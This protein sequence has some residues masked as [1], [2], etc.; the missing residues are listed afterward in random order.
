MDD[1]HSGWLK[2]SINITLKCL[3]YP[4]TGALGEFTQKIKWQSP[5]L[6]SLT[7]GKRRLHPASRR[8]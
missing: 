7:A 8:G 4:E 2:L 6:P 5:Y 3:G 1:Q